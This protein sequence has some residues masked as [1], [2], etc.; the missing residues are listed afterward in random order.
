M[1]EN[2]E[3]VQKG[4]RI[5]HPIMASFVCSKMKLVY[6]KNW[7]DEVLYVLNDPKDLP[8]LGDYN[9]L[10][11]SLDIAN[12]LRIIDREWNEVFKTVL[13]INSRTWAKE[14][15]GIRNSVAH[16][17]Q[18][19]LGQ[20]DAE[21]ALDTMTRLCK[22]FSEKGASEIREL[23]SQIRKKAD[24]L[25]FLE[26][27][28]GPVSI[29]MP[30]QNIKPLTETSSRKRN[31]LNL[32]GTEA[33]QK[34][35]LTRKVTY[36]GMTQAYPV[37]K[38]RLDYLFYND[39]N[40]RIATWITRYKAENGLNALDK[41]PES[42]Y[43]D[44][45]ESFIFDS[46]PDS[47]SKTQKNIA[48]VGQRE[49]GV[50]LLNGRIVD[51]NRRYTCLRR[52][53]RETQEIL[54]FETVIMNVDIESDRKQIKLLELSIQHGEEKKVDYDLIDYAIGTYMDVQRTKLLSIEEYANSTN[55]SISE[56]KKRIDIAT[57]ICEFLEYIKLPEQ[58]HVAREY[59]VYSI[60][61][62]MLPL[63]KQLSSSE[64]QEL[65]YIVFNNILLKALL[66]QRKFIRDIKLL[67]K[68]NTY[69]VY[70]EEQ[71]R[72]GDRILELYNCR[73]IE[74]KEDIDAFSRDND[75]ISQELQLSLQK[76]LLLSRR[77]L[78][79]A[80]PA[81]NAAKSV[82]LLT[83]ID[84][85]MFDKMDEAEKQTILVELNRLSEA[86][87]TWKVALGE[88]SIEDLSQQ[89]GTA[90]NDGYSIN[91]N[92]KDPII[93][94]NEVNKPITKTSFTLSF[95]A[96]RENY[97]QHAETSITAFFVDSPGHIIS[98][99]VESTIASGKAK[100]CGFV[101]KIRDVSLKRMFLI[102]KTNDDEDDQA[103]RIIPFD[104]K[105]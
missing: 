29:D 55:E 24:V 103:H 67:I 62:E 37:Y 21:R 72:I 3:L 38:V 54:Y 39:Q 36:A 94:C 64:T 68:N 46:N 63:F 84:K 52:L 7:W 23:Y 32:V 26:N 104:I 5:L 34:T 4:F 79:T 53:Q 14:L 100:Q 1:Q 70:F 89:R 50:T 82:S 91:Q 81:E 78:L 86:I 58:F 2:Y 76:A 88:G 66:D 48:L 12:C 80:K 6:G 97:M 56:V 28:I 16:I 92:T 17:G 60:F 90:I 105:L 47:I 75:D 59:Q 101:L 33:V 93:I 98:N 61:Q 45:I 73:N 49:P 102:I 30:I 71:K 18:Q 44:I 99:V 15:M 85:R 95:G 69:V 13:T 8:V 41:L 96:V 65:K 42:E 43:N 20:D 87:T 19:D 31:L 35:T 25:S 83:E 10:V 51:G 77:Q 11:D 74:K 57:I 22:S 9:D 40:D 27:S